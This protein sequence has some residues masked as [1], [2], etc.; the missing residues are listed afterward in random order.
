MEQGR[1]TRALERGL[2]ERD[3]HV[4]GSGR[5]LRPRARGEIARQGPGGVGW[6]GSAAQGEAAGAERAGRGSPIG[7]DAEEGAGAGGMVPFWRAD[8]RRDEPVKHLAI[9]AGG[10]RPEV[11]HPRRRGGS[12]GRRVALGVG[13]ARKAEGQ[14]QPESV[15][16]VE[17]IGQGGMVILA[18]IAERRAEVVVTRMVRLVPSPVMVDRVGMP[19]CDGRTQAVGDDEG[20]QQDTHQSVRTR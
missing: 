17:R 8:A 13:I 1:G 18:G 16:M 19:E 7:R 20:R 9:G 5:G 4:S 2:A 14:A 11:G 6:A 12:G 15:P 10:P 3:A